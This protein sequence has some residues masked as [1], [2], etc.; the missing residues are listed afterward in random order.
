MALVEVLVSALVLKSPDFDI[1]GGGGEFR[2]K[3]VEL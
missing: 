3:V 1:A 2:P